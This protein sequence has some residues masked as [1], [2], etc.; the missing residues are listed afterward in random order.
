MDRLKPLPALLT[1]ALA[2]L[3]LPAFGQAEGAPCE[4]NFTVKEGV[5]GRQIYNTWQV[6]PEITPQKAFRRAYIYLIRE[7][8][9]INLA[10]KEFGVISASQQGVSSG[11]GGKAV[12]LNVLIEDLGD[13]GGG[14]SPKGIKATVTFSIP[15][16]LHA[17]E[18]GVR[19]SF[20][21]MLA[22]IKR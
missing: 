6:L 14:L 1:M 22:D 4:K 7:G 21:D 18:D 20:C 8:W 2:C 10:D 9:A 16:G 5:L 12:P 15:G 3:A 11:E 13:S 19:G 17:S